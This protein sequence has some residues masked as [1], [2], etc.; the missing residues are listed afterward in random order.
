MKSK[1][2]FIVDDTLSDRT[3]LSVNFKKA[4]YKVFLAKN[5]IEAY[6]KFFKLK[7][8]LV[9]VD[10][11]LPKMRGDTLIKWIKGTQP[12]KEIPFIVISGH[13]K[14]KDYLYELGVEAFFEKP[15]KTKQV[16][17][18]AAE[19]LQIY[20]GKKSLNERIVKFKEKFG[21][22]KQTVVMKKQKICEVCQAILPLTE[23]RCSQ[24]ESVRL[25]IV[26]TP[27]MIQSEPGELLAP[28]PEL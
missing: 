14:M 4:G 15:C 23:M 18:A 19:V 26:E 2:V 6:M 20:E 9:L 12:G 10:I 3:L 13:T 21:K 24:C 25:H 27:E 1:R 22:V 16:L 7:P 5:G 8:D 28:P 17:E 11:L